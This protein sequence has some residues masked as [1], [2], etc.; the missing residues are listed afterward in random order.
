[1]VVF[2]S[3]RR[4]SLPLVATVRPAFPAVTRSPS[5]SMVRSGADVS[6]ARSSSA[7]SVAKVVTTDVQT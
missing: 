2:G 7:S 4:R 5:F 6:L 3:R 1:M